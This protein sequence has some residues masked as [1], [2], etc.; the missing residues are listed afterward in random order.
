MD[1]KLTRRKNL[2]GRGRGKPRILLDMEEVYRYLDNG[3]TVKETAEHF[4][5]CETTLRRHH[6]KHQKHIEAMEFEREQS[7]LTPPVQLP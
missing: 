5:V 1:E 6:M 4:G 3:H 2:C 7:G